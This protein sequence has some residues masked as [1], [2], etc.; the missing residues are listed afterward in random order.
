MAVRVAGSSVV[1]I[2]LLVVACVTDANEMGKEKIDVEGPDQNGT[3]HLMRAAY[4]N[5]LE[6][7]G[8]LIQHKV[9][10]EARNKMGAT[11]L[12]V[13]SMRG[14]V[15]M[16]KLLCQHGADANAKGADGW[17]AL[18]LSIAS[19]NPD[20]VSALLKFG[21]DPNIKSV[22][23]RTP[24]LE[25]AM[26]GQLRVAGRLIEGGADLNVQTELGRTPLMEAARKGH[27]DVVQ[28][29]VDHGADALLKNKAK[30]TALGQAKDAKVVEIL[31]KAQEEQLSKV[32]TAQK[33]GLTNRP[34]VNKE[35][36]K[37]EEVSEKDKLKKEASRAKK[38][39]PKMTLRLIT[40][41]KVTQVNVK[42][43]AT[44]SEVTAAIAK[45]LKIPAEDQ[46]L[47][48]KLP[49]GLEELSGEAEDPIE[50]LG[51][52]SGSEIEVTRR[53]KDDL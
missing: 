43:D 29:L 36:R 41:E 21:A 15:D 18:G 24:L 3:T 5:N 4:E 20:V 23:N 49:E 8:L 50:D 6:L 12:M 33:K 11:A 14:H 28:L 53:P 9:K 25:A 19:G 37:G 2:V 7:A 39:T 40:P 45:K 31:K 52:L 47:H 44:F 46:M 48:L 42:Q 22:L 27:A 38:K 26:A 35:R 16:V 34:D 1:A 17:G 10:M 13:A 51:V 30:R 32:T